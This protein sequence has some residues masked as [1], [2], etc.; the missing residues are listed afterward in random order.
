MPGKSMRRPHWKGLVILTRF[1][2]QGHTPNGVCAKLRFPLLS[3]KYKY[4]VEKLCR[5]F[6]YPVRTCVKTISFVRT[7][8]AGANR[9][10]GGLVRFKLAEGA[11]ARRWTI[12]CALFCW[13][14]IGCKTKSAAETKIPQEEVDRK[15]P[16]ESN[17]ASIA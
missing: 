12:L 14:L 2:T 16:V 4:A 13:G 6:G 3:P 10:E 17:P 8:S 11:M 5:G 1:L 7:N 9:V 15:N